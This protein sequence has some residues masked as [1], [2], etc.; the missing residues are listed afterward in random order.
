MNSKYGLRW[1]NLGVF[2]LVCAIA[3][4]LNTPLAAQTNSST[5]ED[6]I[7]FSAPPE[8]TRRGRSRNRR[9]KRSRGGC[10]TSVDAKQLTAIVPIVSAGLT[11]DGYPTFWAYIPYPTGDYHSIEFELFDERG[12]SIYVTQFAQT[13]DLP[14]IVSFRL[15]RTIEPLEVG[16]EYDWSVSVYCQA[17]E[18]GEQP[19]P[20]IWVSNAI[21]RVE[22]NDELKKDLAGAIAEREQAIVYARHGL[23]YDTLTKLGSLRRLGLAN[24]E[25]EQLLRDREVNLSDLIPQPIID[26]CRP[27]GDEVE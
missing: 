18:S 24:G 13:L 20:V 27:T 6:D 8:L 21:Q 22:P 14:G 25:W 16:K 23:W 10:S 3:L 15:P 19:T 17:P 7:E 9:G 11:L 5:T 4:S 2:V 12:N 1:K 26:C